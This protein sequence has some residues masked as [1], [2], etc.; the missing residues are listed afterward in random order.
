MVFAV[1]DASVRCR[2]ELGVLGVNVPGRELVDSTAVPQQDSA[3]G[4]LYYYVE[5][6][7]ALGGPSCGW[8]R[9]GSR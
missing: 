8:G 7:G 5:S 9:V 6:A 2:G 4:R 3:L 1:G